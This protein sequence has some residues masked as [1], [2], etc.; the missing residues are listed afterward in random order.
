M[1]LLELLSEYP[2]YVIVEEEPFVQTY[3]GYRP[4][5]EPTTAAELAKK[6]AAEA[7]GHLDLLVNQVR[8]LDLENAE[9]KSRAALTNRRDLHAKAKRHLERY[10]KKLLQAEGKGDRSSAAVMDQRIKALEALLE[11]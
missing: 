11:V 5:L 4:M 9:L 7:K 2:K 10:R 3:Y 8:T 1:P 6:N